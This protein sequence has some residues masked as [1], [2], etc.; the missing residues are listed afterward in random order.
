MW[1]YNFMQNAFL[2]GTIIAVICGIVSYFV[3]IRRTAFAAHAL[4][5]ISLTGAAAAVMLG[6]SPMTGLLTVN[7][8]SAIIMGFIGDKIKK[9][10]LAV[11]IVLTFFLGL[12]AY[13]LYL[14]QTGYS[15][16]VMAIMF[17]DI[18]S[19]SMFQIYLLFLLSAI[20]VVTLLIIAKPLLFASIDPTLAE[21]KR[22][23]V[24]L[25]SVLFFILLAIT[26]SMACQIVGAL[27]IFAL[28]IGPGAVAS[29]LCDGFYSSIITSIAVSV[30]TVWLSLTVSFYLNL[31]ASFCITMFICI[32]YV[33][34]VI[35]NK[36]Y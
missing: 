25:L 15:G 16:G 17:G 35:K 32:F 6:S 4:G 29:Y 10:D 9:N 18:L 13:F 22:L 2:A 11:G 5:H 1:E 26:V 19:V 31:P 12:G 27:L 24:R 3:I 20:I 36:F 23:P 34:G 7:I 21:A 8:T 30:L 28:L 33:L 14:Y